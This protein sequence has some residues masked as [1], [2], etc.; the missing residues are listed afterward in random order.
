MNLTVKD[1]AKLLD[2]S[3]KTI[4]RWIKQEFIPAY[5]I[6]EQYRFNRAELLEWA[7]SQRIKVAAEIFAEPPEESASLPTLSE[8]LE[9]GGVFYR[10]EGNT[11]NEVLAN[12][13]QHLRL[14]EEVNREFLLQVLVA[15]EEIES[16]GISE[17]IAIPHA[18]N[19]IVQHITRPT[20]TLCFLEH[21]VDFKALDD[22]PVH[23]LFT[24]VTPTVR[25]HLHLLSRIAFA[26]RDP[27]FRDLIMR[28]GLRDEILKE[29]RRVEAG[30]RQQIAARDGERSR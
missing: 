14:P 13:V 26:L 24:I 19:P 20:V 15:R 3:E 27:G 18:R 8:A 9:A 17:G 28:Q 12:V 23:T 5:R 10:I 4:Y 16:T 7:T 11:R 22:K 30:I 6:N 29:A 1:A 21:P 2:V 25:S